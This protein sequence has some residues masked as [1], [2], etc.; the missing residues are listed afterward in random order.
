MNYPRSEIGCTCGLMPSKLPSPSLFRVSLPRALAKS[1]LMRG[2][3]YFH[4]KN[5]DEAL[6][7]FHKTDLSYRAPEWQAAAL[8]EAGKV[9]ERTNRWSDAV[10]VYEKIRKSFPKDARIVEVERRLAEAKKNVNAPPPV[11]A[12]PADK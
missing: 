6:R 12:P 9:Y 8:L 1:Q 11:E 7:E 5:Y 2:E 10:D 3:T 4:Q